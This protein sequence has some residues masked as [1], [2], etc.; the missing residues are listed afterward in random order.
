VEKF[1]NL[2]STGFTGTLIHVFMPIAVKLIKKKLPKRC[3]VQLTKE[4]KSILVF[5]AISRNHWSD[6]TENFYMV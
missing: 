1:Q 5:S 2:A 3:V 6:S 4:Y